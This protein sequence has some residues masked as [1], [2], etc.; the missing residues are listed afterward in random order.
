MLPLRLLKALV[1]VS[2]LLVAVPC[3]SLQAAGIAKDG[4]LS[5]GTAGSDWNER[6][7]EW[8]EVTHQDSLTARVESATRMFL[9]NPYIGDPLGEGQG[10]RYDQDD[11]YRFDG[12]DCTTFVETIMA[13]SGASDLSHFERR[14]N[15]IRYEG[16]RIDFTTRNHFPSLDWIPNNARDGFIR[17]V[18]REVA[19]A[20]GSE[21]S[22]AR[23][24]ID[25]PRWYSMM[26]ESNLQL[27]E[28]L[29]AA[30]KA[31][32]VREWRK[33]GDAFRAQEATLDY[34]RFEEFFHEGRPN[35]RLVAGIPSGSVIN[36]VRPNWDL[37]DVMGTH[38]NVSH[39]MIFFRNAEGRPVLRHASSVARKIVEADFFAVMQSYLGHK[40]AKGINIDQILVRSL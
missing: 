26:K 5:G 38:M 24:L 35:E 33:E 22:L 32:R 23:A 27:K 40:T 29:S 39:Q 31:A 17:D 12:F 1:L 4:A 9:G 20:G 30:E 10:G 25:K 6:V 34:I 21:V 8:I 2:F 14:M 37:T 7:K 11:L 16:G 3:S 19:Q 18:T 15:S 13:L 36:I 28:A